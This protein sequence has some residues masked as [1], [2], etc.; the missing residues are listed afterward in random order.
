MT[1]YMPH[2]S[3]PHEHAAAPSTQY[4]CRPDPPPKSWKPLINGRQIQA[5]PPQTPRGSESRTQ[6]T[7]F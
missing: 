5:T 4:G 1:C 7:Q 6:E 2:G 3:R